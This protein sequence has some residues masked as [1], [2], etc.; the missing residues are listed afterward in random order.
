[1]N[2]MLM[3]LFQEY[4]NLAAKAD[5]V[6]SIIE[7][8]HGS[9]VK[10]DIHCSDCC[11]SVFGLFLIESVYLNYHFYRLDEKF[12]QEAIQRGDGS[13]RELQEFEKRLQLLQDPQEVAQAM[14]RERVRCP[15]LNDGRRCELY[16]YRPITCRAYGIP[17]IV[18]GKLHACWKAGFEKGKNYPAFD[19]DGAY[20]ELYQLSKNLLEMAGQDSMERASLLVSVS[21]SIKTPVIDLIDLKDSEYRSQESE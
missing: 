15:L 9:C 3:D 7:K 10:C 6:F 18:N 19:L 5:K 8:E 14:A 21:K 4:E 13:D 12:R 20:K 17:T 2:K 1:M 16:A 11:H